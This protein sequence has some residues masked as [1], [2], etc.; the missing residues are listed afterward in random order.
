MLDIGLLQRLNART[1]PAD[2]LSIEH[3]GELGYLCLVLFYY[4]YINIFFCETF[5]DHE[6]DIARTN[7]EYTHV[8]T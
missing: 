1:A 7:N 8:F 2:N 6:T 5:G 4:I 3:L